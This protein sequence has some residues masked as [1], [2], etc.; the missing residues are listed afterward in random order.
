MA[1]SIIAEMRA[2]ST[3]LLII[4]IVLIAIRALT[5]PRR[6]PR[7]RCGSQSQ[8]GLRSVSQADTWYHAREASVS[9]PRNLGTP[10]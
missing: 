9:H 2:A 1:S 3:I 4:I 7:G 6:P 5:A 8:N 10:G